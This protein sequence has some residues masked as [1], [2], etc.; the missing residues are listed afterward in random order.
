MINLSHFRQ[1][2][3][4]SNVIGGNLLYNPAPVAPSTLQHHLRNQPVHHV[5]C[6]DV[7]SIRTA[8]IVDALRSYAFLYTLN[9]MRDFSYYRRSLHNG[10]SRM[11]QSS[12]DYCGQKTRSA[13]TLTRSPLPECDPP[14]IKF[15]ETFVS[16]VNI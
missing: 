3:L 12:S 6:G 9:S 10:C 8:V 2:R 15:N 16:L 13:Y 14:I 7:F 1:C 4:E 11:A 5:D